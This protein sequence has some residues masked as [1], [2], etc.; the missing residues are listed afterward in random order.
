[1][2]LSLQEF[3]CLLVN[4]DHDDARLALFSGSGGGT[5]A[6]RISD[7]RDI[8]DGMRAASRVWLGEVRASERGSCDLVLSARSIFS[9][10]LDEGQNVGIDDIR[11]GRHQPVREARINLERAIF[12]QFGLQE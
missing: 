4:K 7:E 6:S 8:A 5:R 3:L 1:M 9:L 11:M 2:K 10:M 12:E